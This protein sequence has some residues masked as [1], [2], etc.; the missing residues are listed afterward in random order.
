M[1]DDVI[2]VWTNWVN[3]GNGDCPDVDTVPS[4]KCPVWKEDLQSVKNTIQ[5]RVFPSATRP[6]MMRWGRDNRGLLWKREAGSV[7]RFIE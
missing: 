4:A 2:N 3:S 5:F 1:S 7:D 6:I